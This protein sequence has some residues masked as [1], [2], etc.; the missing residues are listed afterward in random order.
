MSY[1][2]KDR[3]EPPTGFKRWQEVTVTCPVINKGQP[4]HGRV[5]GFGNAFISPHCLRVLVEGPRKKSIY[6]LHKNF[7]T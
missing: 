7:L 3:N 6:T 4:V 1:V 5:I 2:V